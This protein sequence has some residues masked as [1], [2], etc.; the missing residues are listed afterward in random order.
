MI[1][2]L[3]FLGLVVGLLTSSLRT[4]GLAVAALGLVWAA[5]IVA[6]GSHDAFLAAFAL[7]TA[8]AAV[9]VAA[10]AAGRLGLLGAPVVRRRP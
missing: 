10:G 1:P 9:G 4:L 5:A 3:L 8:N 7:G 6:G 2:T